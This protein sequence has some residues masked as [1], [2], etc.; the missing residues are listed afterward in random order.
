MPDAPTTKRHTVSVKQMMDALAA[1][2][3]MRVVAGSEG[4]TREI[5]AAEV[6][7]TGLA[8]AGW[9][10]YF[11]KHR[12]QVLGKVEVYYLQRL[13]S[14][15]RSI[16]LRTLMK[17]RIPAFI[18]TRNYRAPA[19]LIELGNNFNIP[20]IRSPG[21]TMR[22]INKISLWLEDQFA[23]SSIVHGTFLE[24]Y[25]VG[26][27]IMGRSS[28]GK[29]ECALSLIE[30]GHILVADD[31]VTIRVTEGT[32]LTG[33]AN[34]RLGHHMEIRGIGIINVQSLYGVK[35]VRMYK[36]ID[37]VVTLVPWEENEKYDRL[38]LD[39]EYIEFLGIKLPN[40]LM[41]VKSGRDIALL[42][43]TAAQNAKLKGLGFSVAR[44]FNEHLLA[45]MQ[46]PEKK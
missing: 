30:R 28:V 29:S 40:V 33:Y 44:N 42:I 36:H 37:F 1:D 3:Q 45:S 7:R 12:I 35:S 31:I 23:P 20:I 17:M 22:V 46:Y 34:P 26:V 9:Y 32:L 16:R 13:S 24:V 2:L 14:A 41:P 38:G 8:L 18:V 21:V 5:T 10:T 27:L 39:Q 25:G 11:A 6:N 15:E 19:E 4:L 43:E